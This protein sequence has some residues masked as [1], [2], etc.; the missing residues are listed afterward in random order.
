MNSLKNMESQVQTFNSS[1]IGLRADLLKHVKG[2]NLCVLDIGC[3]TGANGQYLKDNKIAKTVIGLE[4]DPD[5][6]LKARMI[7]DDVLIGNIEDEAML[8][9]LQNMQ[10]DYILLG[11][12]LEHLV[13]PWKVLSRLKTLLSPDGKLIISLPNIQHI[14]LFIS[15]YLKGEWP[16]NDRGIFDKTHLR[17][18]TYKN[19]CK[20]EEKCDLK[21]VDVDRNF[22]FRDRV[23]SEFPFYGSL[24]RKLFPNLFTFQ[25]IV[26]ARKI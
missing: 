23:G 13:D 10:F 25:F 26:V 18:F 1:Y 15:I 4:L 5:M 19:I 9:H 12:V 7:L 24:L 2:V 14:E 20:F 21:I 17:W 11:D 16:H 22:R 3:A 6:A 8:Y